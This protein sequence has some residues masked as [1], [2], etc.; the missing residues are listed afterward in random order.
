MASKNRSPHNSFAHT[1]ETLASIIFA[2]I[3]ALV[4]RG[5]VGQ[6]FVIP[7]GSM[8]PTLYGKHFDHVC[9]S[10]GYA[11]AVGADHLGFT[12]VVCPN[13][14]YEDLFTDKNPPDAGDGIF[15]LSWPFAA[16]GALG[17]RRWDVVVFKAPFRIEQGSELEGQTNYIKRLIGL[18]GDVIELIDGD[19]YL[20]PAKD[21]PETIQAKL[22]AAPLPEP[23]TQPEKDLVNSALQIARKTPAAQDALWQIV[24]DADYP[25][26]KTKAPAWRPVGS[27]G[28]Q[29]AWSSTGRTFTVNNQA[30][31][32]QYLQLFGANFTDAYGYNLGQGHKIVSDLQ[33]CATVTWQEGD[34]RILLMLSSR[35]DL[36]TMELNPTHGTGRMVQSSREQDQPGEVLGIWTFPPMR[37]DQPVPVSLSSVDRRLQVR[38]GGNVVLRHDLPT[39][40]AWA[41]QQPAVASPPLVAVGAAGV[42]AE[43]GHLQVMRDVYYRDD[44]LLQ[45]VIRTEDGLQTFHNAYSDR[46][47]WADRD[48]PMLLRDEEYFV[49]G[50]N[51]PASLDSRRWWQIGAH[52]ADRPEGYRVG[53]VPADQMIGK[54]YFVY[55]PSWYTILNMRVI[56][57]LGE[58]RW[59]D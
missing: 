41:K 10:C 55:W 42:R 35:D 52:L 51:S 53:T 57:N 23:L 29:P 43:F 49:L 39:T 50:D 2:L 59:I 16:G 14:G 46:P 27:P 25:P 33:L 5:F 24:F 21:L 34:G 48:N 3:L 36:Y 56:P 15:T 26:T 47:G 30:D 37:P 44:V 8:A 20:A 58:M 32:P 17:P 19:V 38:M 28:Q 9:S 11:F 13:C 54:A 4:F 1:R 18:P 12:R 31:Q 22:A 7:T 45:T 40:A 6:A